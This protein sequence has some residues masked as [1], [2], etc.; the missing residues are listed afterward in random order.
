MCSKFQLCV[1][2]I[3]FIGF[4]IVHIV[5]LIYPTGFSS[6]SCDYDKQ[7]Y[8]KIIGGINLFIISITLLF[9]HYDIRNKMGCI[10]L[11]CTLIEIALLIISSIITSHISSEC[12]IMKVIIM[13][14]SVGGFL[15]MILMCIL[16]GFSDGFGKAL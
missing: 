12:N 7:Y 2:G 10:M 1:C 4:V 9:I 11:L 5:S 16:S 14:S 15:F 13:M 8:T 3:I 6:D